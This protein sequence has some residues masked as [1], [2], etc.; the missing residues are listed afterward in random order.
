LY[1]RRKYKEGALLNSEYY[2]ENKQRVT[3]GNVQAYHFNGRLL[4]R[5]NIKDGKR[6]GIQEWFYDNGQLESKGN[7][8]AGKLDGLYEDFDEEGNLIGT[9]EWKDGVLQE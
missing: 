9:E 6:N 8:K 4:F 5:L 7:Y 1:S 3:D 2:D